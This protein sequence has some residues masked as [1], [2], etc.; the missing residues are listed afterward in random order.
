MS[1]LVEDAIVGLAGIMDTRHKGFLSTGLL[2]VDAMPL[3]HIL[4]SFFV[5]IV[6]LLCDILVTFFIHSIV[7]SRIFY[8]KGYIFN[9]NC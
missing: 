5:T 8:V 6:R 3:L 2:T 9:F 7:S 1:Q 4:I